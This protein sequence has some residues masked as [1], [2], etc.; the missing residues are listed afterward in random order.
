MNTQAFYR[1]ADAPETESNERLG[2]R[3][4]DRFGGSILNRVSRVAW[5][6]TAT[7]RGELTSQPVAA[8]SETRANAANA[9]H[10]G[11]TRPRLD[12]LRSLPEASACLRMNAWTRCDGYWVWWRTYWRRGRAPCAIEHWGPATSIGARR[13]RGRFWRLWLSI[14]AAGAARPRRPTSST[15]RVAGTAEIAG[16]RSTAS[17]ASDGTMG[18]SAR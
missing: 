11:T 16:H 18:R 4:R 15:R 7:R 13:A 1:A 17:P 5:V 8:T 6:A 3:V 10:W 14:I 9:C 2:T 12:L